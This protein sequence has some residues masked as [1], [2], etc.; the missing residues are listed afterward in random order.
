[1]KQKNFFPWI[2]FFLTLVLMGLFIFTFTQKV[3]NTSL[4][5]RGLTD[6]QYHSALQTV[7]KKFFVSY[8]E[9]PDQ[10]S[11]A[12]VVEQTLAALLSMRVPA[13]EKEIHLDLAI[14][15]AKMKQGFL[16]NPQDID[17]GFVSIQHIV[18]QTSWLHL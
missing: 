7:L 8:R 18:S 11:R 12:V 6:A 1:M 15:L 3:N 4:Q 16:S 5:N 14:Q 2:V 17:E 10:A 9:A 13:K